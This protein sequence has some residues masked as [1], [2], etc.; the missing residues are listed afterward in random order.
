MASIDIRHPHGTTREDAAGRT[1]ALLDSFQERKG[2]FFKDVSWDADGYRAQLKGTG[3]KGTFEV[4]DDAIVV[5]IELGFL[6]RAFK[7]Q[8]EE[9]LTRKLHK[10]FG[11]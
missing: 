10:E 8:V 5:A 4:T 9:I 1:R 2:E 3:F 7:G 11:S 6:A